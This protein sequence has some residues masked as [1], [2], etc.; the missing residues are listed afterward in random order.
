MP[1]ETGVTGLTFRRRSHYRYF[2]IIP[3]AAVAGILGLAGCGAGAT[4]SA[5]ASTAA[6]AKAAVT[7]KA[8]AKPTPSQWPSPFGTDWVVFHGNCDFTMKAWATF[9]KTYN[10]TAS[11]PEKNL[12]AA[13]AASDIADAAYD[14]VS[15]LPL[16][17]PVVPALNQRLGD[18]AGDFRPVE[19]D[20]QDGDTSAADSVV[21]GRLTSDENAVRAICGPEV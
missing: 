3:L 5:S 1:Q 14:L 11:L 4:S 10:S 17:Q 12:A 8:T 16:T 13:T 21:K 19:T 18:F 6:T 9:L 20:L 15:K 7:A 2:L